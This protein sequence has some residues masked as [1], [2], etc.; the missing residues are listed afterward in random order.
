M[1][2]IKLSSGLVVK[3]SKIKTRRQKAWRTKVHSAMVHGI[4]LLFLMTKCYCGLLGLGLACWFVSKSQVPSSWYGVD[5]IHNS[6]ESKAFPF[7]SANPVLVPTL[8]W[9]L[10]KAY[11]S[12]IQWL[13]AWS[14]KRKLWSMIL[15]FC[16][17]ND[18]YVTGMFSLIHIQR[19]KEKLR[20]SEGT[21]G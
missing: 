17:L 9:C 5:W 8:A 20:K 21:L 16:H 6:L 13:I 18:L 2:E 7:Q 1:T 19:F 15:E 3:Y 11:S 12:Y 14:S 10:G 4:V